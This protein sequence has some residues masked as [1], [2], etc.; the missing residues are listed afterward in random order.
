M[1]S[2]LPGLTEYIEAGHLDKAKKVFGTLRKLLFGAGILMVIVG[3]LIGPRV[4]A[5]LTH[6]K[7]NIAEMW[8]VLPMMLVL[9]AVS[10]GYD[11]VFLTLFAAGEEIWFLKREFLALLVGCVFF[12]ASYFFGDMTTKMALILLGAIG[13][14]LTMVICG[15]WRIR[16]MFK[17]A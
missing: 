7:Y 16:K 13:G 11:L 8:F 15:M 4:I 5:L 2:A 17:S 1:F 9:A 10:Y 14:E 6:E 3:S 12:G